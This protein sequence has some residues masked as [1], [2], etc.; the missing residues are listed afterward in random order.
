MSDIDRE[1]GLHTFFDDAPFG[2][3]VLEAV[4]DLE[5]EIVDFIFTDVNA[6]A[7]RLYHPHHLLSGKKLSEVYESEDFIRKQQYYGSVVDQRKTIRFEEM[8]FSS[9]KSRWYEVSAWPSGTACM[10]SMREISRLKRTRKEL[11][12]KQIEYD[13]LFHESIDPVFISNNEHQ[14]IEFNP[15]MKS[16]LGYHEEDHLNLKDLFRH[17]E[18]FQHL[19]HR[20]L[21]TS[22]IKDFEADLVRKDGKYLTC[23]ISLK[24]FSDS[25]R[26]ET[27]L[28]F[29]QDI[30]D[31]KKA[32]K[33]LIMAEKLSL[34]GKIARTIAHEVRNPLTNLNL[35]LEQLKEEIPQE[36]DGAFYI[37]IL[38]RNMERIKQLIDDLLSSSKPKDYKLV[39]KD[40]RDVVAGAVAL[41]EDRYLLKD[42]RIEQIYPDDKMVAEIDQDQIQVAFLNLLVNASEAMTPGKGCLKISIESTEDSY[43]VIFEDNGRGIPK[44]KIKELFEPFFSDSKKS[45]TGL[46]LT[47]VQNII[48]GHQGVIDVDSVP[49]E[50]TSFSVTLPKPFD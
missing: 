17:E 23:N 42:M 29:L 24:K 48:Q 28:G 30:T 41:I 16:L 12:R 36:S 31:R 10:V 33:N 8:F 11:N 34:T 1:S 15:E 18:D 38:R 43:Q 5:G 9:G 13:K 26:V 37:D 45:G 14:V 32:E 40:L 44:Q 19:N 35:A 2:I 4:R 46:G 3:A 47:A 22:L 21:K 49:G 7:A 39:K 25:Q 27:Y 50:G 6:R 20:L